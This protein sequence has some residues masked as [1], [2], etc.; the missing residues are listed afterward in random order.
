MEIERP[1]TQTAEAAV[2]TI[3]RHIG[4]DPEREGLV[5]TPRRVVRAMLDFTTGLGCEADGHLSRTFSCDSDEI[6]AVTGM[7]FT[8]LFEHH[9][10]PFAGTV[11]IAY[12]PSGG[13][14]VGLSKLARAVDCYAK[15]LQLQ[16]R[17]TRQ[18]AGA[19]AEFVSKDVAVIVN[20]THSCLAHRGAKRPGAV[21][22]TSAMLGLFRDD[23]SARNEA[24][25]L[26]R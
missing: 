23:P 19:V 21:M 9:L 6:I 3:L 16:E 7:S 5:D 8:S 12:R 1:D 13:V 11:S 10:L 25:N 2:R 22:R 24:L 20:A 18:V 15:R 4:E 26:L 17:M 14:V